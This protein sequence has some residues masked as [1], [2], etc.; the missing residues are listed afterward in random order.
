VS[1]DALPMAHFCMLIASSQC[2]A[3]SSLP[4]IKEEFLYTVRES[5]KEVA[6][7]NSQQTI[8]RHYVINYMHKLI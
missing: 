7:I 2:T 3:P 5:V 1:G 4:L 6:Y 8:E